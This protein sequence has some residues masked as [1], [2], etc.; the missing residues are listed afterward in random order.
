MST[1]SLIRWLLLKTEEEERYDEEYME[2][3]P[4]LEVEE[5]KSVPQTFSYLQKTTLE[6]DMEKE[7]KIEEPLKVKNKIKNMVN[8][9]Y[10]SKK[11]MS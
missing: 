4:S 5:K 9:K 8:N 7:A 11:G 10:G 1:R 3:A 2:I 6:K